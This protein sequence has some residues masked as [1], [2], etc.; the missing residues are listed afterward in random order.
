[1]LLSHPTFRLRCGPRWKPVVLGRGTG[2]KPKVST[3][4]SD[5]SGP[6]R[7]EEADRDGM[8]WTECDLPG[9]AGNGLHGFRIAGR[10]LCRSGVA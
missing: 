1:M 9:D 2:A 4:R 8:G 6:S 10:Q 7:V 3:S 5:Q